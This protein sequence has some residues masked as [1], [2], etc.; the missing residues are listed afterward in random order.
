MKIRRFNSLFM[1]LFLVILLATL[2]AFIMIYK[3]ELRTKQEIMARDRMIANHVLQGLGFGETL[4]ISMTKDM[5]QNF[6]DIP[7]IRT[8]DVSAIKKRLKIPDENFFQIK[9]LILFDK[10]GNLLGHTGDIPPSY[11]ADKKEVLDVVKQNS[12][13]VGTGKS[14]NADGFFI[15]P[16]YQPIYSKDGAV[17]GVLCVLLDT[18]QHYNALTEELVQEFEISNRWRLAISDKDGR[19]LYVFPKEEKAKL[20]GK[21]NSLF[22]PVIASIKKNKTDLGTYRMEIDRAG[23]MRIGNYFSLRLTG[24]SP[25]YG[26]VFIGTSETAVL[27]EILAQ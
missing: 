25:V 17:K 19:L 9:A 6:A 10:N 4:I 2:P 26:Y 22:A 15:L 20:A 24:R 11:P 7:E 8:L 1:H 27:N 16:C 14:D 23:E 12:F 5:L 21:M 3:V 18:E 13:A